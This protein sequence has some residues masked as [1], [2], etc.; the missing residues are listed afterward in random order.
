MDD[1]P[2]SSPALKA[3]SLLELIAKMSHA[4]TLADLTE[5]A[6]LPKPTL[7][8]WLTMLETAG[9]VRRLPDGR[10]YELAARA[11][12]LAFSILSNSPGSAQRQQILQRIRPRPG[13]ILQP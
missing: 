1:G 8:R 4:P 11:T 2:E 9:M 13:G 7:H 5:T 12:S 6:G 3:F 10:R